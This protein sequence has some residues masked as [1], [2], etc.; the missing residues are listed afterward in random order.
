MC[1]LPLKVT[2]EQHFSPSLLR[3]NPYTT[4]SSEVQTVPQVKARIRI[5]ATI[6]YS[7][8]WSQ[9]EYW[10]RMLCIILEMWFEERKYYIQLE[11]AMA[12]SSAASGQACKLPSRNNSWP[13]IPFLLLRWAIQYT[14]PG[15]SS[16]L[17][18]LWWIKKQ[19]SR[20]ARTKMLM[21]WLWTHERIPNGILSVYINPLWATGKSKYCIRMLCTHYCMYPHVYHKSL[22][23]VDLI[24]LFMK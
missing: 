24:R 19:H 14:D 9:L 3:C 4:M 21:E 20:R 11:L 8:S 22:S 5:M 12:S 10:P 13:P 6:V 7:C 1:F 17:Q 23:G 18:P 15:Q 16:S 2:R